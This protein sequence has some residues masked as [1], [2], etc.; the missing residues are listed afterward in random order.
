LVVANRWGVND[1]NAVEAAFWT[2]PAK[3]SDDGAFLA[4][5]PFRG[6]KAVALR[7]PPHSKNAALY[8]APENAFQRTV[9][10]RHDPPF[11]SMTERMFPAGSLNQAMVGPFRRIMPFLSVVRSGRL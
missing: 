11:S 7:F 10:S 8:H 5:Q 2:A 1:A 3:R 6:R 4:R 9:H